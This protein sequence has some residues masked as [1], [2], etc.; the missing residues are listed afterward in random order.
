LFLFLSLLPLLLPLL[1]LLLFLL[2]PLP[3]PSIS[4]R[5]LP[6]DAESRDLRSAMRVF[7]NILMAVIVKGKNNFVLLI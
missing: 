2:L 3:L 1:L 6:F 7:G 4:F 5:D